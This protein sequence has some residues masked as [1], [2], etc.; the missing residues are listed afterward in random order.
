MIENQSLCMESGNE[1]V[2]QLVVPILNQ[3]SNKIYTQIA[4]FLS[5]LKNR[6]KLLNVWVMFWGSIYLSVFIFKIALFF[7]RCPKVNICHTFNAKN[8]H[9]KLRLF[10]CTM[11]YCISFHDKVFSMVRKFASS[12]FVSKYTSQFWH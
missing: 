7:S 6:A 11:L 2:N 1:N 4:L 3:K 9:I 8:F 10:L 12:K 5:N